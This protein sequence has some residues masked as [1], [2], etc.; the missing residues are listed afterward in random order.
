MNQEEEKINIG[1]ESKEK[2]EPKAMSNKQKL[3]GIAELL[4]DIGTFIDIISDNI[5][6]EFEENEVKTGDELLAMMD[7]LN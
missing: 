3:K 4:G 1:T 6:F 7:S 2:L 5:N